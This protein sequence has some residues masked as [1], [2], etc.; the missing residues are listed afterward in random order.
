MGDQTVAVTPEL[1]SLCA[2]FFKRVNDEPSVSLPPSQGDDL[3][4]NHERVHI[5]DVKQG[6]VT[7]KEQQCEEE[8]ISLELSS[9]FRE[10]AE[11]CSVL[12]CRLHNV[13]Q[14]LSAPGN[15]QSKGTAI[16]SPVIAFA[17]LNAVWRATPELATCTSVDM[18]GIDPDDESAQSIWLC[19]E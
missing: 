5:A 7:A 18:V 10:W 8:V 4:T 13:L 17:F 1:H 9:A 3:E 6:K 16:M 15:V 19:S 2:D 11:G 12:P 14:H